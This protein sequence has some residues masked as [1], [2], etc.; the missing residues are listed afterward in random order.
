MLSFAFDVVNQ[1]FV[2]GYNGGAQN[3]PDFRQGKYPG[4]K[5]YLVQPVADFIPG[6][7][8]E[9]EAYNATGKGLRVGF[10][11][12]STGDLGDEDAANLALTDQLGWT[13]NT[14]DADF[15]YFTGEINTYTQQVADFV[16]SDNSKKAYFAVNLTSGGVLTPVFDH[17]GS[18]NV[19]LLSA[20]DG[21]GGVPVDMTRAVPRITLPMELFDP[22][23]GEIYLWSRTA[24]GVLEMTWT[25]RP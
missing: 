21:G 4:T 23:S 17:K 9:Y 22:G 2:P 6:Q 13:Y 7:T 8:Q 10:W 5:I 11:S 20:T 3:L 24:A 1:A 18:T 15:P 19:T 16:A 14:D 25:N 12:E